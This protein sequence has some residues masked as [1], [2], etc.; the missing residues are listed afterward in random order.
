MKDKQGIYVNSIQC[1]ICK[2]I[3]Y[4]R[5]HYDY[6]NCSCDNIS[7][8]GGFDYIR[9]GYKGETSPIVKKKLIKNITRKDLYDDWNNSTDKYG[10][11]KG[12]K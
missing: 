12:G 10:L 8:D 1:P 4:S 9:I 11:I 2:D 6:H 3:I 7:I 5:A